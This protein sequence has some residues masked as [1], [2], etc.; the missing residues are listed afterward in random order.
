MT[1]N[2]KADWIAELTPQILAR[3]SDQP[4]PDASEAQMPNGLSAIEKMRWA[5]EHQ[6]PV[7]ELQPARPTVAVAVTVPP[8]VLAMNPTDRMR[9]VRGQQ[10]A[11]E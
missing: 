5:R 10:R 4:E 8:D 2:S 11:G 9:W 6:P 1:D 7:V 3:M